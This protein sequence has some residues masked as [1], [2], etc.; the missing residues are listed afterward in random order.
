M[1]SEWTRWAKRLGKLV[2]A[3]HVAG[4]AGCAGDSLA[5][6][7]DAPSA[8]R[9]AA[10]DEPAQLDGESLILRPDGF[11]A[12]KAAPAS[13]FPED[14][15]A[16]LTQAREL[17]R[18]QEYARAEDLFL[19]VADKEK[20]PPL[21]IQEA[22]YYRAECLRLQGHVPKAADVYVALMNKFPG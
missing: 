8:A 1:S 2:L 3:A 21:A 17:F 22:M 19:A 20:N 14:V 15:T 6:K 4:F 7:S 16:K 12:E 10:T 9:G 5:R 18:A 11:S 13:T